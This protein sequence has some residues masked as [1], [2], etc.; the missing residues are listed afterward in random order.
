MLMYLAK[1][2]AQMSSTNVGLR[3]SR[4]HATVLHACKQ[5]EER[6]TV[7]DK[8]REEV[9]QLKQKLRR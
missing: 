2:E 8:L 1:T 7:E 5:I 6:M 4:N 9:Q 3:L